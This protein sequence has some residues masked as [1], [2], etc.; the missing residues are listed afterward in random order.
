MNVVIPLGKL[1]RKVFRNMQEKIKKKSKLPGKFK[2][3]MVKNIYLGRP[4]NHQRRTGARGS[5]E[6]DYT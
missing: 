4:S 2:K 5:R 3:K 1:N 6:D